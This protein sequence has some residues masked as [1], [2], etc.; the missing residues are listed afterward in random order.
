[1]RI[2]LVTPSWPGNSTANGIATAV[3]HLAAGLREIGHE[4]TVIPHAQANDEDPVV[5]NLPPAR[6]WSLV[7]KLS[8]RFG[9]NTAAV[10]IRAEQMTEAVL[11]AIRTR[12]IEVLI[13]EETNGIAGMIQQKVPIPVILTLHGPWELH[14]QLHPAERDTYDTRQRIK[15]EV[16]AFHDCAGV[17]S[18]SKD[19]LDRTIALYGVPSGPTAVIANPIHA[20]QPLDAEVIRTRVRNM[21]F[22]GRY[23][24]HKGGDTVIEAFRMIASQDDETRLTFVGPDRGV[25]RA[26]GTL[27]HIDEAL[28]ALPDGIR[29]RIGYR[30]QMDK[31]DI[32]ALRYC[33][34]MAII[35]SRYENFP[36][37]ALEA[38]SCGMPTIATAVGGLPE[39]VRDM[40]TGLLVPA[41][42]S[43]AMAQACLRLIDDPEFAVRLGAQAHGEVLTKYAPETIAREMEAFIQEVQGHQTVTRAN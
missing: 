42:A 39:I 41:E 15:R 1:M 26:D 30:G 25:A 21:L 36:Y 19:V 32:E 24:M 12:G 33:H 11:Q 20:L 35:G 6:D 2:G 18:P 38:L 13:M 4:I 27:Q 29:S 37:T 23:D 8:Q 22:I 9:F 17:T 28:E 5:I 31:N 7:E 40:N 10:P 43:E 34:G 14:I 3:A 16:K